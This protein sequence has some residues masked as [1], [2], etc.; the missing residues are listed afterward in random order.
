MT[1][2]V[3]DPDFQLHV[4][5][6][7][8]ILLELPAASVDTIVTSPPYWNL[9]DYQAAGQL[10]LEATVDEYVDELVRVFQAAARVLR[11]TGTL[12][13][14]LGDSYAGG[15][16]GE[17][18]RGMNGRLGRS[19]GAE[20][21][22]QGDRARAPV[23]G[24]H[25]KDLLGLPWRVAF[26]LQADGW[27]L[28]DD[29][30]WSKPN[31][32]PESATDRPTRSHEYLFMLTRQGRYYFAQDAV[33]E[34]FQTVPQRRYTSTAEQPK[35]PARAAAGVQNPTS[36]GTGLI[37][38]PQLETLFGEPEPPRRG[39]GRRVTTRTQADGSHENY[40][41]FGHEE[42]RERWPNEKGRNIRTV[43]E[44]PTQPYPDAHFATYPE[45][46]AE[47]CIKASCPPDGTV[48]DPFLG[49]GTTALAARKLGRRAVGIELNPDYARQLAARRLS[50]QSLLA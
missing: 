48:L 42:G 28:R 5:D 26:A 39:D 4:G 16:S 8:E 3:D 14:N 30:I 21:Q 34:P 50:Q 40:E 31:A 17:R 2:L 25:P 38:P 45:A 20:K 36:Q 23:A 44:I 6:C 49:S 24:L 43:W 35:G 13:L 46:L 41:P 18:T 37:L 7:R 11:P 29:C 47:R 15:S 9:R 22:G 33:R 19:S 10:G 12:W 27:I 32:M 1:L